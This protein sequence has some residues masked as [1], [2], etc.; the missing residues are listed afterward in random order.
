MRSVLESI[1]KYSNRVT[2]VLKY[3]VFLPYSERLNYI[4]YLLH[5]K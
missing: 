3:T 2:F 4:T 5:S 1:L